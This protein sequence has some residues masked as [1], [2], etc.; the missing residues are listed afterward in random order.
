MIGF[1]A[2]L[3]QILQAPVLVNYPPDVFNFNVI[4]HNTNVLKSSV[5]GTFSPQRKQQALASR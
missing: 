1:H 5:T 4:Q 2:E 3:Y